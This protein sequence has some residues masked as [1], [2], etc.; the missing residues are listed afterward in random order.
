MAGTKLDP[1]SVT[2]RLE[3]DQERRRLARE[4]RGRARLIAE[5]EA[6]RNVRWLVRLRD[7]GKAPWSARL[8]AVTELEDRFGTPRRNKETIE[9]GDQPPKLVVI[10]NFDAD[11]PASWTAAQSPAPPQLPPKVNG[12]GPTTP[13]ETGLL[14]VETPVDQPSAQDEPEPAAGP[15]PK[16]EVLR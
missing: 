6:I 3:R 12:D 9:V 14:P 13:T 7:N 16:C 2:R 4:R 15:R 11:E 10:R 5:H 8:A 1:L